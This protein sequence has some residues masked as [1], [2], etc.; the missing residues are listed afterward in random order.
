V[1]FAR[2]NGL[3]LT[4]RGAGSG[5]AGGGLGTGILLAFHARPRDEV[6]HPM[7]RILDFE[8]CEGQPRVTVQP[9]VLHGDLQRFLRK[10]QLYLP[11]DPSSGAFCVLGGNLATKA[12]GPHALKHGSIDRYL[13]DLQFVTASGAVI[14]TTD[15]ASI[16]ASIQDG[17]HA[18][19]RDLLADTSAVRYLAARQDRKLASGYNLF[20]FLRHRALSHWIA[21]LLVGS[22]GTLGVITRAALRAEP[23]QE[24]RA[25]TLLYFR[26]L[27]EA[28]EAVLHIRA[29]DVA[30]IEIMNHA[31]IE[32]ISRR[33][34]GLNLPQGEAH[35]LLVE[36][37]G[38]ERLEQIAATERLLRENGYRLAAPPT[39]VEGA[40][41]QARLWKVRKA[42]LPT[43]RNYRAPG[44]RML[45][46]LSLVND[47]GV[48]VV[49]LAETIQEL[50]ALF[51]QLGLVAAIYGH[52]GSGNLHL[53]PLFD[54]HAPDLP[55]LLTR[56]ADE[57]YAIVLRHDGTITAEHGMGR[58]R[59]PYL[60][61]EWGPQI[62][63][64]LRRVKDTF[65]PHDTLN[66]DVMF[67]ER[68][69]TDEMKEL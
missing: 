28:G 4:P 1:R 67:S 19:C 61:R 25:T 63:T 39:T 11:A 16:P 53:R 36:Y 69:L 44:G 8:Q 50:E 34:G 5:T 13:L 40:E 46:A 35:M 55:A 29:L 59:A 48:P 51:R 9:G 10:R 43:V 56:V 33:R 15:P 20:T 6:P 7:N 2:Q 68:S 37:E 18:L 57:V 30:A 23:Y 45:K 49:H 26:S 54:P 60:S 42:A 58:L 41:E 62:W 64:Y 3:P 27:H 31:T 32:I 24:K 52:A 66:P 47:V 65:D 21:Q 12:S 38:P 17:L 22:V 14:D